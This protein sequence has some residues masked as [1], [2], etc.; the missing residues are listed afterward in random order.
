MRFPLLLVLLSA[1]AVHMKNWNQ[2]V[3]ILSPSPPQA[4]VCGKTN[5][6]AQVSEETGCQGAYLYLCPQKWESPKMFLGKQPVYPH[7]CTL[8][9]QYSCPSCVSAL[10]LSDV[11]CHDHG[12]R[13]TWWDYLTTSEIGNVFNS[14]FVN[15][16]ARYCI[17]KLG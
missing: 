14:A 5:T 7:P 4:K 10:L 3:T 8:S 15:S 17:N 6:R 13:W 1:A 11:F 2:I 9:C 16:N 12:C